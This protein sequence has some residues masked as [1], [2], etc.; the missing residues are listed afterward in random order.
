[1]GKNLHAGGQTNLFML[2]HLELAALAVPTPLPPLL[3][4][5]PLA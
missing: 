2:E 4:L 1:M 5:T 3:L